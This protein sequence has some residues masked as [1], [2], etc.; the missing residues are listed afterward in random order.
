MANIMFTFAYFLNFFIF[1]LFRRILRSN[2]IKF[3]ALF[4]HFPTIFLIRFVFF[5]YQ[6]F[7]HCLWWL[8][9]L[10]SFCHS[11]CFFFFF[12]LHIIIRHCA[13][14]Q[15]LTI[16]QIIFKIYLNLINIFFHIF[17]SICYFLTNQIL[18]NYFFYFNFILIFNKLFFYF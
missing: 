2:F 6:F 14:T 17:N 7:L 1:S 3:M 10:L 4:C 13:V 11:N 15:C 18:F 12:D 9:Y 16:V 5:I 8:F